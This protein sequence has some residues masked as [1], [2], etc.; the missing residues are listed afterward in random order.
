VPPTRQ[1]AVTSDKTADPVDLGST[2]EV[3]ASSLFPRS[4]EPDPLQIVRARGNHYILN[5]GRKIYM[6]ATG[7]GVTCLAYPDNEDSSFPGNAMWKRIHS[8]MDKQRG[9]MPAIVPS[10]TFAHEIECSF[11]KYLIASTK[12]QLASVIRFYG[13]GTTYL[14]FQSSFTN[15][16]K[17]LQQW[18]E[19]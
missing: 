14:I 10:A 19:L 11:A 5:D 13:S 16:C 2:N 15:V 17:A 12:G 8:E 1:T 6:G 9:L 7:A 18:K 3:D 4:F